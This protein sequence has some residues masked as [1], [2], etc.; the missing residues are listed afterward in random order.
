MHM[1]METIATD[2]AVFGVYGMLWYYSPYVNEEY[3]RWAG[4]MFRHF[5]IEGNTAPLTTD[6][7]V[8]SHIKNGDFKQG[9]EG[10]VIHE[11]QPGSVTVNQMAGYGMMQNRYPAGPKGNTFL[12]MKRSEKGPNSFSQEMKGLETGRLY[13]MRM[14]TADHGNITAQNSVNQ[15]D[16]V[17]IQLDG[18]ELEAQAGT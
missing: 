3:L 8:L 6:P 5:G 17:S 2:P 15:Q 1:Q 18:V 4:R 7:Y 14:I 10:W 16:V 9:T 11:A 12:L 13:S